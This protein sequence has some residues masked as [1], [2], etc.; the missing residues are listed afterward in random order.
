[1]TA[2]PDSG[3]GLYA[4]LRP[5]ADGP[6]PDGGYEPV[7]RPGTVPGYEL[8]HLAE[9]LARRV[10]P[11]ILVLDDFH[12]VDGAEVA[13]G[14]EFLL[15]HAA[16]RLRLVIGSR[17]DPALALRRWRLSGEL[18]EVRADPVRPPRAGL[19][20]AHG[21]PLATGHAATLFARTEGWPAGLRLAALALPDHPDPARFVE[22]FTGEHQ[23]VADYLTE[24]VLADLPESAR[25]A[26]CRASVL[27]RFSG[28]LLGALVEEPDAAPLLSE[29][30]RR[31]GFVVPLGTRPPAYRCHP[32]LRELLRAELRR[33]PPGQVA[34]LHRRAAVWFAAHDQ[35][36]DALRHALA[37]GHWRYAT[38]VLLR[39]W[40][41]LVPYGQPGPARPAPPAPPP[42]LLRTDPELALACAADRL[43][44][45]DPVAAV[46][47]LDQAAEHADVLDGSRRERLGRIGAALRLGAAHLT[48]DA[49]AV[50]TGTAALLGTE[51]DGSHGAERFAPADSGGVERFVSAGS[52]GAGPGGPD[53]TGPDPWWRAVAWTVRGAL[54]LG[55]GELAAEP[56]LAA[57]QAEA[58][59]AGLSR[60]A[61]VCLGR[62]ALLRAL[63]GELG[64]AERLARSGL[65]GAPFG[66]QGRPADG[67]H[68]RLAQALVALHRDRG[69]DAGAKLALATG[70]PEYVDEPVAAAVAG[71]VRAQLLRDRGD[72]TAGYQA[73]SAARRRLGDRPEVRPLAHLLLAAEA[74]LRAAHGDLEAARDLVTPALEQRLAP[75]E[76]LAVALSRTRLRAGDPRTAGGGLPDWDAPGAAGWPLP[77]RLEAGLLDAWAGWLSGDHRRAA[78]TLERV[79]QLA[80]PEGFRRVFTRADPPVRELLAS[81][82]DSGTA[83]WPMLNDLLDAG[84]APAGRGPVAGPPGEPLTDR[85]LTVL[86]YLQSI[87]SNVEIAAEMSLSVN[88]IKTHVRNIYRKLDATRRRDAVRRAREL[89]LI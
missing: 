62:L 13:N 87:L 7:A 28:D 53:G 67:V 14:L 46:G 77:V 23:E 82:L 69:D 43:D 25:E 86:R 20:T 54:R 30:D 83:Y 78:R 37:G 75:V 32:M 72:L 16:G 12:Q 34:G 47:F 35:P 80:E 10:E 60:T 6:E 59:R 26:L 2:A 1:M 36:A 3:Q 52:G 39:R 40:P 66:G 50:H 42:D 8:E 79:L 4:A 76:P 65:D 15:R 38:E 9:E 88:T 17:S 73:L 55:A 49:P 61:R 57:G 84:A 58:R 45:R 89:H 11:A 41:D 29:L 24:E 74:D 64:S 81:H 48:G 18:T 71:L 5:D 85:E 19:F 56:D 22:E 70:A 51:Q 31:T 44:G 21:V 68:A 63:A 33:R 27:D